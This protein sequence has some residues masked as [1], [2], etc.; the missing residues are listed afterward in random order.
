MCGRIPDIF[1]LPTGYSKVFLAEKKD[2]FQCEI[3]NDHTVGIKHTP[4]ISMITPTDKA[5][6]RL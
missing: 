1:S 3:L 4:R 6:T 5:L 2:I